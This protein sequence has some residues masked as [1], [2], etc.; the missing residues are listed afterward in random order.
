MLGI[1][2]HG[3]RFVIYSCFENLSD[4]ADFNLLL[5]LLLLLLIRLFI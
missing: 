5:L 2:E 4:G 1:L 3:S